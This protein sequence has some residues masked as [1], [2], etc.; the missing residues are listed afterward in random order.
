MKIK[1]NRNVMTKISKTI[2]KESS[3]GTSIDIYRIGNTAKN[4]L[5]NI[6]NEVIEI[7]KDK[8]LWTEVAINMLLSQINFYPLDIKNR[9][10]YEI[11]NIEDLKKAEQILRKKS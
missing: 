7:K 3:Y 9:Y 8:I 4:K 5:F 11:D 2:N 6:I 1:V 10:W